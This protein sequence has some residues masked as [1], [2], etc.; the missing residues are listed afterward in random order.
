MSAFCLLSGRCAQLYL[1]VQVSNLGLL[2]CRQI[3]YYLT[4]KEAHINI[5]AYLSAYFYFPRTLD[6]GIQPLP[7]FFNSILILFHG[8][9]AFSSL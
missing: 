7:F 8:R 6:H 3:L 1:P 5:H 9:S 4:T 2:H